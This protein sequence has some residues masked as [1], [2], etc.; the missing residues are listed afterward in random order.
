[1]DRIGSV[2]STMHAFLTMARKL[3]SGWHSIP[4]AILLVT[5]AMGLKDIRMQLDM[6]HES[7]VKGETRFFIKHGSKKILTEKLNL[8]LKYKLTKIFND[9]RKVIRIDDRNPS[10]YLSMLKLGLLN[11]SRIKNVGIA[12]KIKSIKDR[13]I[14]DRFLVHS[15]FNL[16]V[17]FEVN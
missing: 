12:T 13:Q 16:A 15:L 4:N 2:Q 3:K 5:A 7:G 17:E 6:V 10:K 14:K 1:M 9:D 11:A 8:L